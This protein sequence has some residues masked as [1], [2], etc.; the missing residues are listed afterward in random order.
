MRR[1]D[2]GDA[3]E[4]TDDASERWTRA[5]RHARRRWTDGG[6]FGRTARRDH[7][8]RRVDGRARGTVERHREGRAGVGRSRDGVRDGVR[9]GTAGEDAGVRG[10]G[11]TDQ[12]GGERVRRA[13][14]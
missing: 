9:D 4:T 14:G 10:A 6:G 13:S 3:D 2:A 8:L 7:S 11:G 1:D 12:R 5:G